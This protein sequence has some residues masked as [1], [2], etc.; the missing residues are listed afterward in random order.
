MKENSILVVAHPDDEIL[1][2]NSILEKVNEI[3]VCFLDVKSN[4]VLT[5]GRRKS[6]NEYPLKNIVWLKIDESET[7]NCADWYNPKISK[8]GIEITN[9]DI[10]D[11]LYKKNY[12]T[13][14]KLL[15]NKMEGY[16]DVFT[17]NPWGEY[18]NEEHVQVYRVIK[19]LQKEMRFN[20]WFHIVCSN[21]SLKLMSNYC[22]VLNS[23]HVT[24]KSNKEKANNI[25]YI[26]EKNKCWTWFKKWDWFEEETF[27]KEKNSENENE[28]YGRHF[29]INFIS[30]WSSQ[31]EFKNYKS[32][33]IKYI[34]SRGK[35]LISMYIKTT[36]N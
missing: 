7:F 19:E 35:K 6:T 30:I 13:L 14:K 10:S 22:N 4:Q 8:Y 5:D 12:L 32:K 26:Y 27:I 36:T 18:G 1:W 16:T 23:E 15:K 33:G 24:L 11:I 31:E 21:K 28:N 3:I 34:K 29:P 2:F 17:H 20:L 9:N 25:R